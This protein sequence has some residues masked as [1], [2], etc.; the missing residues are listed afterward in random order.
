[1]VTMHGFFDLKSNIDEAEFKRAYDA[2]GDYLIGCKL[3]TDHKAM[4]RSYDDNYDSSPP[5]TKYYVSM[6]FIDLDQS[7]NCWDFIEKHD[8]TSAKLHRSVFS[9]IKNYSFFL[10][11]DI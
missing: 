9:K 6:D 4:R 10:S 3:I 2:F 11:E 5:H 7:Q 1:M 8:E